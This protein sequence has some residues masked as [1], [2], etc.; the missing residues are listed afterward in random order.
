M[1]HLLCSDHIPFT[2]VSF[3]KYR[4]IVADSNFCVWRCV[5][6]QLMLDAQTTNRWRDYELGGSCRVFSS[7]Q[8]FHHYK[9]VSI[10]VSVIEMT[11][12]KT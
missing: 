2:E 9:P 10:S 12:S 3:P 5:R 11:V 7:K 8:S 4:H 1:S 6:N